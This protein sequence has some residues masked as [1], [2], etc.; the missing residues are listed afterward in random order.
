MKTIVYVLMFLVTGIG[1]AQSVPSWVMRPTVP[2][3]GYAEIGIADSPAEALCRALSLISKKLTILDQN[4]DPESMTNP[5]NTR[6]FGNITL[7]NLEEIFSME[8]SID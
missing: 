3:G 6:Q 5:I 8:E 4:D 7:R 2:A 1:V